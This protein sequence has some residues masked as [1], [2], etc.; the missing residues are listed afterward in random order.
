MN[1]KK[2]WKTLLLLVLTVSTLLTGC[3]SVGGGSDATRDSTATV[4]HTVYF[5]VEGQSSHGKPV[6]EGS[7]LSQP[8]DPVKENYLF[9]GWYTDRAGTNRYDFSQP[10]TEDLTLYAK[11]IVD[12]KTLTNTITTETIHSVVRVN[13]KS[14][15]KFWFLELDSVT[16]QGSGVIFHESD[17]FFYVLTNCH[18]AMKETDY[19]EVSYTVEDYQGRTYTA[20]LYKSAIDPAYD[21]ACLYF[22]TDRADLCAVPLADDD[23]EIGDDV[24]ALGYPKGQANAVAFG[25]AKA[26]QRIT[27]DAEE[28]DSNVTFDVLAHTAYSRGGSSGGPVLNTD[29]EIAGLHYADNKGDEFETGYA[30]PATKIREFLNRYVYQ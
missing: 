17:G 10:V 12:A 4:Y 9:I 23:P 15:N 1:T 21:L 6:E 25:T 5:A 27:P 30:I 16:G 26:Y 11:F 3:G 2:T 22:R 28:R 29:L 18:V 7:Y 19:D 13:A 24:I 14:Y 8:T 20:H